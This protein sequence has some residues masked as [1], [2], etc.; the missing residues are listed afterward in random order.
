V[1]DL[2]PPEPVVRRLVDGAT[3][4]LERLSP[5]CVAAGRVN[6]IDIDAVAEALGPRWRTG[7]S[8]VYDHIEDVLR[9]ALG[10]DGYF[11]RVSPTDFLV[12]QPQAGEFAA[13]ALCFRAFEEIWSHLLGAE[14]RPQR[15]VHKVVDLSAHEITAVEA[16][17]AQ[18]TAGEARER[19]EAEAAIE[20]GESPSASPLAPQ[21]WAPFVASNGRRLDVVCRLEPVFSLK[22]N[23]R[24]ATRLSRQVMDVGSSR[25]LRSDEITVLNRADLFRIDMATLS[26][27][28]KALNDRAAAE[29]DLSLIVPASYIA[30]SHPKSR[31][32]F[33]DALSEL[34]ATVQKGFIFELFDI[35]GA[36]LAR[37]TEVLAAV[38]PQCLLVVGHLSWETPP[39]SLKEAGLQAV[40]VSCPKGIGGD[41]EFI[42]W[43][44]PWI[45]AARIVARSVMVYQCATPRRMAIARALNA[46]HCSGLADAPPA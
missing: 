19:A 36:P 37:L 35:I 30:M 16:D 23:T 26:H 12:V 6:L 33:T 15:A 3:E 44:R 8:K 41:A 29:P 38:R 31:Q 22:S 1:L 39:R 18:A 46:T 42:G 27:G 32:T 28:L 9:G 17:P 14:A 4:V 7:K 24:I 13:Q 20:R 40:A 10:D 43:L 5:A 34:R 11:A 45:A 21:L 25:A 2:A